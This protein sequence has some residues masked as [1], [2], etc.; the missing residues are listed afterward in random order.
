MLAATTTT[1]FS[2]SAPGGSWSASKTSWAGQSHRAFTP[3]PDRSSKRE[4]AQR[5]GLGWIGRNTCLIS[6]RAGSMTLLTEVLLD[7]PLPFDTPFVADRCG[8]CR[9]CVEACPTGCILPDRTIDARRCISYLTIERV[10]ARRPATSGVPSANG[11]SG[12]P[13][14]ANRSVRG[15]GASPG[16]PQMWP[17]LHAP[18]CT[19]PIRDA[20]PRL[21]PLMLLS[22]CAAARQRARRSGLARNA[23]VVAGDEYDG[24]H[25][26]ALQQALL[27][28]PDRWSEAMLPGR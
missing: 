15:T 5:A 14:S 8:S 12:G 27:R 3:T 11:P 28:D 1:A 4:L 9:H 22:F 6:P 19:H 7:L 25:L 18:P 13:T 16:R 17:S 23:A 26:P 24:E 10:A 21:P 2:S 20:G